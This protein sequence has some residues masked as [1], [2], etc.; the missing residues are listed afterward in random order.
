MA[1]AMHL[2][3]DSMSIHSGFFAFCF[4]IVEIDCPLC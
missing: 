2:T 1:A 4:A 3:G